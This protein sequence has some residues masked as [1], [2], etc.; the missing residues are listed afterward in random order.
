MRFSRQLTAGILLIA[1][2]ATAAR[3]PDNLVQPTESR[4][5]LVLAAMP[6]AAQIEHPDGRR[7]RL[8]VRR[9]EHLTEMVE[10]WDGW[11]VAGMRGI[12]EHRELVLFGRQEDGVRRLPAPPGQSK[13]MR[14]RPILLTEW[15]RLVGM[16]WVEGNDYDGLAVY[17][18]DWNGTAWS[19]PDRVSPAGAGNQTGLTGLVLANGSWLLV[20]SQFDG[21][22]DEIFWSVRQGTTWRDPKRLDLDNRVPDISPH[23][24]RQPRGA[25][26]AWNRYDGSD[27]RLLLARFRGGGWQAPEPQGGPGIVEP[28]FARS[29]DETYLVYRTAWPSDWTVAR[30]T[31]Q[32]RLQRQAVFPESPAGR[33]V[34]RSAGERGATLHWPA[35]RSRIEAPWERV[36]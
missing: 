5:G 29:E 31:S 1:G 2:S 22:D 36:P 15:D 3:S 19:T 34:L 9:D 28:R 17:A 23:L 4:H 20:W 14:L 26:L 27:Y 21:H 30:V 33:P 8:A 12:S 10:T 7:Q 24:V 13:L 11:V 18:A 16:A 35:L 6:G 32:G 25:L